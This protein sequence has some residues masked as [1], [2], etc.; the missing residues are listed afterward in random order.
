MK[1]IEE[2]LRPLVDALTWAV[3]EKCYHYWRPKLDPPFCVWQEDSESDSLTTDNHKREQAISG[4]IDYFTQ[5][6]YDPKVDLIQKALTDAENI[7]WS[8]IMV[9]YEEDSNLIHYSWDFTVI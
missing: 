6:E 3:G 8:L 4:S 1:S 2:R 5:M 7:G 9:Q